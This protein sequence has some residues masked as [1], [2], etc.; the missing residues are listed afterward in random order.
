[1]HAKV[2]ASCSGCGVATYT[3]STVASDRRSVRVG[4]GR[5][6]PKRSQNAVLFCGDDPTALT[7]SHSGDSRSASQKSAAMPPVPMMPKL[8]LLFMPFSL[9]RKL[10]HHRVSIVDSGSKD[11]LL[12]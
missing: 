7:T 6:K 11:H 4:A 1:M 8:T 3:T 10:D 2:C 12:F 5:A 9:D